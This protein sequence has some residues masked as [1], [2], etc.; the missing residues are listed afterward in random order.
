[1]QNTLKYLGSFYQLRFNSLC[2][3]MRHFET[4]MFKRS[5]RVGLAVANDHNAVFL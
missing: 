2:S 3:F 1:M 4:W 5:T